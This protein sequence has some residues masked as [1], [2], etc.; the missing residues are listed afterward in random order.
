MRSC[1]EGPG[2]ACGI[3]WGRL[4]WESEEGYKATS[5]GPLNEAVLLGSCLG[6][7]P[8]LTPGSDLSMTMG[9]LKYWPDQTFAGQDL[10]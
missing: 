8:L 4:R 9:H 6:L 7:W 2:Q 3:G 10:S 1:R 5:V